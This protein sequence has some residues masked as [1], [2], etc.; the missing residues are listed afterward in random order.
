MNNMSTSPVNNGVRGF[1]AALQLIE[2]REQRQEITGDPREIIDEFI[3]GASN[4]F[5]TKI[6]NVLKEKRDNHGTGIWFNYTDSSGAC[7]MSQKHQR[8][9]TRNG[10]KLAL[11]PDSVAFYGH[12]IEYGP[13]GYRQRDHKRG[14]TRNPG[15]FEKYNLKDAFQRSAEE[16]V[17]YDYVEFG[18]HIPLIVLEVSQS[19]EPDP[20]RREQLM[21][22]K[23]QYWGKFHRMRG[24]HMPSS[25]KAMFVIIPWQLNPPQ[26]VSLWHQNCKITLDDEAT[27]RI[28]T[29]PLQIFDKDDFPPL[30][31]VTRQIKEKESKPPTLG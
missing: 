10:D 23:R 29:V 5:V 27:K 3:Q 2:K 1:A 31:P 30:P 22:E 19:Y 14:D 9:L 28:G 21:M 11:L 7:C 24:S 18:N 25:N 6:L 15:Q 16:I 20:A 26:M 12:Q 4:R 17:S 8:S 13:G